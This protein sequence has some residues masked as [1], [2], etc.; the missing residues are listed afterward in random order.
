MLTVTVTDAGGQRG[1]ATVAMRTRAT[2]QTSALQRMDVVRFGTGTRLAPG[3]SAR[4]AALRSAISAGAAQVRIEGF[5][6]AAG[7]AKAY[8]GPAPGRSAR[9]S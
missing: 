5:S 8:R 9:C 2:T 4:I 6:R 3:A 7:D 1:Q